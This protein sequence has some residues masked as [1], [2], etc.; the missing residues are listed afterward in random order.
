MQDQGKPP[1]SPRFGAAAVRL[2]YVSADQVEQA[3][4]EQARERSRGVS[5]SPIGSLL[6]EKGL[7]TP[8]QIT[9]VLQH[10]AGSELP[11]S[12]DGI[13]LAARL[14]VLHAAAGNVIGIAGTVGEDAAIATAEV[15]V[16]LAVMEQGKVLAVDANLRAPSLHRHLGTPAHPGFVEAIPHA[17]A[18]PGSLATKV[19]ALNVVPAGQVG[20]DFV[21]ACMSPEAGALIDH[22]RRHHRYTLVHLGDILRHPEAAVTA[23]RCDGVV[24]VLRARVSQKSEL[25]DMQ[26]MLVGLQVGLSG[27]VLTRDGKQRDRRRAS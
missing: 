13:R 18:V 3:L 16:A 10:L 25:R 7:L 26:R 15:A 1:R 11:L 21:S 2:G 12:E 20:S 17:G 24:V 5:A 14:K 22:Y 6:H 19:A 27:V 23:S 4:S 8:Q 9:A